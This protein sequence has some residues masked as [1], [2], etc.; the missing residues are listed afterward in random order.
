MM[1]E[2]SRR[3]QPP[4]P[5]DPGSFSRKTFVQ[6]STGHGYSYIDQSL[7]PRR[8]AAAHQEVVLLLHGFPDLA[9]GWRY[10]IADLVRRGYRTIAPDLLGY[11]GTS[12]PTDVKEYSKLKICQA[13]VELLEHENIHQKIVVVGHDWGSALTFRFVQYFPEKV[14]CWITLCVPPSRPGQPGESPPDFEAIIK[15]RLPH[16]GYQLYF[17]SD[18]FSHEI[19]K[20]RKAL[21]LL[22]YLHTE[23]GLEGP[24]ME[25][26]ARL[27]GQSFVG[28]HVLQ[29]QI[30]EVGKQLENIEIKDPEISYVLSEFEMGGLLGPL[31]WYKT[32]EIDHS[33]EQARSLP[34]TFP[35]DIPCLFLG[36]SKDPAFPPTLFTERAKTK[37]FPGGNID[38]LVI[39]DGNHFMHQDPALRA[40]VSQALGSWI[41]SHTNNSPRLPSSR[42]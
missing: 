5:T 42:L 11:G 15:Q 33:D 13:L 35:A 22:L 4:D 2:M 37:L 6:A 7:H 31:S 8:P 24:I 29:K 16:L 19:N 18:E 21:I 10:Q 27:K 3:S 40:H 17:M 12:K 28:I 38:T 39:R 9:Y 32:R 1:E 41:E 23:R 14:K 25:R 36:A 34:A 20:Y 30:K 26:F